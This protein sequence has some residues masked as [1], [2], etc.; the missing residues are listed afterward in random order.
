MLAPQGLGAAMMMPIAG[1]ASDRTG[2]GKV[3]LVGLGF[4]LV[5]MLAFTQV[6][7]DTSYWLLGSAQFV[8]GLG[9]G[10]TMM[11]AMTAAFQTMQRQ[12]V[13]RA[14]TAMNIIQRV[15]GSI[16]VAL[17]SVVLSHQLGG[18][19]LGRTLPGTDIAGAFGTTFWWAFG[20]AALA[21]IPALVLPRRKP[22][23]AELP[24]GEVPAE[25]AAEALAA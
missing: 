18:G 1:R 22:E 12:Q 11:P 21:A 13:A 5:G 14:T 16:G 24:A 25:A 9:M 20:I 15:G 3:V 10:A 2:A 8:L 4:L 6:A 19:Q 23:P 7:D 17:L